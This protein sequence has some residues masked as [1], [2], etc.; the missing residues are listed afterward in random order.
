VK[1]ET[2]FHWDYFYPPQGFH[3]ILSVFSPLLFFLPMGFY[4]FGPAYWPFVFLHLFFGLSGSLA[5]VVNRV[6]HHSFWT[7]FLE[8]FVLGGILLFLTGVMGK[9]PL[10]Q[11]FWALGLRGFYAFL[12]VGCQGLFSAFWQYQ[13]FPRARIHFLIQGLEGENLRRVV[14]DY[15]EDAS[16]SPS[17]G[18]RLTLFL[19]LFFLFELVVLSFSESWPLGFFLALVLVLQGAVSLMLFILFQSYRQE[20]VFISRGV[21]PSLRIKAPPMIYGL[22]LGGLALLSI[23]ILPTQGY[24]LSGTAHSSY[25]GRRRGGRGSWA[26]SSTGF[27]PSFWRLVL[28]R[29]NT[30]V[31]IQGPCLF[32][33]IYSPFYSRSF[34][35]LFDSVFPSV[36]MVL[37]RDKSGVYQNYW[38][39]FSLGEK[40]NPS[41]KKTGQGGSVNHCL[42]PPGGERAMAASFGEKKKSKSEKSHLEQGGERFFF[43]NGLGLVPGH[44]L[45]P[46]SNHKRIPGQF[47]SK[48]N[49]C[50]GGSCACG[51]GDRYGSLWGAEL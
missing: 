18:R 34:F 28:G 16:F 9:D 3:H 26:R 19:F 47:G 32:T 13:L 42:R 30:G 36:E 40:N 29:P 1:G 2:G 4:L 37:G 45:Y 43:H 48:G 50:P 11:G 15:Q 21:R 46:R 20:M 17:N 31:F 25:R 38:R 39:V 8:I 27:Y 23:Q 33:A 44:S 10:A 49:T 24:W 22:I 5:A 51:S 35:L 6:H 12:L 14:R 7:I 41:G